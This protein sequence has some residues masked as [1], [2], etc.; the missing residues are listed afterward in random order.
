MVPLGGNEEIRGFQAN[1]PNFGVTE[2]GNIVL[3]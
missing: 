1:S 3:F 2:V